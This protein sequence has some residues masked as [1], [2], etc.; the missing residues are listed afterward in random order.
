MST[1]PLLDALK[2]ALLLERRGMAFYETAAEKST[3]ENVR[4]F[5]DLMAKEEREHIQVLSAQFRALL[6]TG[7]LKDEAYA[8][9]A[10]ANVLSP[11][12]RGRIAAAGFESAAISAAIALEERAV[13]FYAR[14]AMSAETP[15]EKTLFQWLADWENT[16]L[17]ALLDI[18][19]EL[20]E[21]IWNDN[22]FW[23]F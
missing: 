20:T 17:N 1:T 15:E 21:S 22:Q 3:D 19:R 18:D 2:N 16:H 8:S 14:R 5:F 11:D 6:S 7:S 9:G 4:L 10:A 13:K 23:P 12:I